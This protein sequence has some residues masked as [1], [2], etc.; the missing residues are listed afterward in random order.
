MKPI[1]SLFLPEE[2]PNRCTLKPEFSPEG[3]FKV[4]PVMLRDKFGKVCE[5]DKGWWHGFDLMCVKDVNPLSS[6]VR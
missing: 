4:T 2:E 5:K 1:M 3:V 6:L